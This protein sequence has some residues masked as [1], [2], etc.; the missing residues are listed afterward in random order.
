MQEEYNELAEFE[1]EFHND[2]NQDQ[3]NELESIE[4]SG[5]TAMTG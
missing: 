4:A 2:E 5:P 3:V 1:D